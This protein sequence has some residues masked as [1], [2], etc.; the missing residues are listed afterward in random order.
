MKTVLSKSGVEV[1][2]PCSVHLLNGELLEV[3][4]KSDQIGQDLMNFI[5]G[6]FGFT[7]KEYWGFRFLDAYQQRHWLDLKK[8]IRTQVK[9]V[10]PI[11][12][13]FRVKVYPPEPYKLEEPTKTQIFLQLRLDLKS[14][15]LCCG[16]SDAA[17]LLGLILQFQHGDYDTNIHFGNYVKDKYLQY[18]NFGIEMKAVS[19]HKDHLAGINKDQTVDLFLRLAS[20]LETYGVDPFLVEDSNKQRM[21]L[22]INYKGMDTYVNAERIHHLEWM[23]ISKIKKEE[24]TIFVH[25]YIED[26]TEFICL[27]KGECNYIYENAVDHLK[28]FTSCG[29]KSTI[30]INGSESAED[31]EEE[32]PTE[33]INNFNE[34][35]V[36]NTAPD[37]EREIPASN[38]TDHQ[39]EMKI[40]IEKDKLTKILFW[41][42]RGWQIAVFGIL[43]AIFIDF[44]F[45]G[46]H[47]ILGFKEMKKIW[48]YV[49]K[50]YWN[51]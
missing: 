9:N 7:D 37:L 22:W 4:Y 43:L 26:V 49:T 31:I 14:G 32:L 40:K 8:L 42:I 21:T 19:F 10:C 41:D 2:Y 15:S 28:F 45:L 17:L 30:G 29:T 12:L 18:Q 3:E 27:T 33:E 48:N 24:C 36:Q 23:A 47:D 25:L 6:Y 1:I 44:Y 39:I 34:E 5:C 38:A 35:D 20:Q 11:H 50:N 51:K 16:T 46:E 13:H